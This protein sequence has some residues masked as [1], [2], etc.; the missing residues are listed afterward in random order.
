[1]SEKKKIKEKIKFV[2]TLMSSSSLSSSLMHKLA[3]S[4]K[5]SVYYHCIS[6]Y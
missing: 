4:K 6:P 2:T 5:P 3:E 1:M